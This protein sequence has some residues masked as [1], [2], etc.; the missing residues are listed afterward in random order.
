MTPE[1]HSKALFLHTVT[2]RLSD[3]HGM[4]WKKAEQEA[5]YIWNVHVRYLIDN[6]KDE[7]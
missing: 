4:T 3:E 2:K 5:L 6:I 1:E 7:V